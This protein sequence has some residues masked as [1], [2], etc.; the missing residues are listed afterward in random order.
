MKSA[1]FLGNRGCV[2]VASFLSV[3]PALIWKPV[4]CL[5]LAILLGFRGCVAVASFLSVPPALKI[6]R[7][8]GGTYL[9]HLQGRRLSRAENLLPV[10]FMLVSCLAYFLNLKM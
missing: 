4:A 1:I 9:P 8:F 5:K 6:N 7:H 2:A 10:S 3:P